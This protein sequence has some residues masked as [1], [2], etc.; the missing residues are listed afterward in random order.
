MGIRV[1]TF[2][3]LP[4]G[5]GEESNMVDDVIKMLHKN[6]KHLYKKEKFREKLVPG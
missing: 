6:A 2:S 3:F 5:S 4:T 1:T